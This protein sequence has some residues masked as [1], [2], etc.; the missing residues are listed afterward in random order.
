MAKIRWW[1]MLILVV[2]VPFHA[3]LITWLKSAGVFGGGT[4]FLISAWREIFVILICVLILTEF[5][6]KKFSPLIPHPSPLFDSLDFLIILYFTLSL[7]WLFI[8]PNKFQWLWGFRYDVLPFLFLFFVRRANMVVPPRRDIKLLSLAEARPNWE[9][10][11][12]F[13]RAALISAAVVLIFGLLQSTILPQN[14]LKNFGYSQYSGEYTPGTAIASCQYL[15]H[16]QTICRAI[17]TF[18]GPTSKRPKQLFIVISLFALAIINIFLTYSR[19][20]WIGT[21]VTTFITAF[22]LIARTKCSLRTIGLVII[23]IF[24]AILISGT[25]LLWSS[26]DVKTIFLRASSTSAHVELFKEGIQ[27]LTA[28]PLGYGLGTAGPAS[29]HFEKFLPENWYLQIGLEMG[30]AGLVIFLGILFLIFKNLL[31][32]ARA[33]ADVKK[34]GLFFALL[35]I[36]VAGLFTHSFEETTTMLILFGFMGIVK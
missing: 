1:L 5:L 6:I 32:S 28:E 19:S 21:F 36:A 8:Q 30:I 20:I 4:L 3:F 2:A 9:K 13:I 17:S 25:A 34:L 24:T 12:V 18:G 15:E 11:S 27:K 22:I 23:A 31:A 16:T 7:I 33:D 35:G 29:L 26:I 10:V 14:F